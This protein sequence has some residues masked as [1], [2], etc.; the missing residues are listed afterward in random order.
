VVV[1]TALDLVQALL[2]GSLARGNLVAGI[3]DVEMRASNGIT[4]D[5]NV[6]AKLV[7]VLVHNSSHDVAVGLESFFGLFVIKAEICSY[8]LD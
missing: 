1:E 4:V 5:C 8:I 2:N 7:L 6:G 3:L